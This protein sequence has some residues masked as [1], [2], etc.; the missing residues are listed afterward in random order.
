M[1]DSREKFYNLPVKEAIIATYKSALLKMSKHSLLFV[2]RIALFL[3]TE[4]SIFVLEQ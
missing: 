4:M 2:P 3:K 1:Q